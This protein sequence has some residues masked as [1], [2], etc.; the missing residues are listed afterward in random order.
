MADLTNT[1]SAQLATKTVSS[2]SSDRNALGCCLWAQLARLGRARLE[3]AARP[4]VMTSNY[5]VVL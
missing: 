3:V 4:S 2:G 1:I 5:L